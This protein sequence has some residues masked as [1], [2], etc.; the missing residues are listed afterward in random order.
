MLIDTQAYSTTI[1]ASNR[2]PNFSRLGKLKCLIKRVF[3]VSYCRIRLWLK[4]NAARRA[5]RYDPIS[6]YSDRKPAP[7]VTSSM[8]SVKS[9]YRSSTEHSMSFD[10]FWR[11]TNG[12]M[13]FRCP[14]LRLYAELWFS[15]GFSQFFVPR[16]RLFLDLLRFDGTCLFAWSSS[17]LAASPRV[18]GDHCSRQGRLPS[19]PSSSLLMAIFSCSTRILLLK[20]AKQASSGIEGF[21]AASDGLQA[22]V[23]LGRIFFNFVQLT[24]LTRCDFQHILF[25]IV[26]GCLVW[27]MVLFHFLFLIYYLL[28]SFKEVI[29]LWDVNQ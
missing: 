28:F 16:L 23:R 24:S 19:M 18:R 17:L 7:D 27:M 26:S 22:L 13:Q 11:L 4:W 15:F 5:G 29:A 6:W 9:V 20:Q 1:E 14:T 10:F 12:L 8:S 3:H 2:N 25:R 21:I